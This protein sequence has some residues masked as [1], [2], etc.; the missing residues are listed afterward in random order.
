LEKAW[1][2]GPNIGIYNGEWTLKLHRFCLAQGLDPFLTGSV[3]SHIMEG[4]KNGLLPDQDPQQTDHTWNDGEKAFI[5]LRQILDGKRKGFPLPNP[6]PSQNEDLDILADLLPF[7]MI[8]VNRLNLMTASNMID[9]IYA[10]TGYALS[11]EDLRDI[12]WNIRKMESR[13]QNK[14]IY[15]KDQSAFSHVGEGQISEILRKEKQINES[16]IHRTTS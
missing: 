16:I 10:A 1:N 12:V 4:V 5:L 7:C 8:V 3:L 13:L 15:L 14:E 11:K 2:L 6:S 9:L